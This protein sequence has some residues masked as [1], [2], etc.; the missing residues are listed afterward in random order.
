[1]MQRGTTRSFAVMGRRRITE[2]EPETILDHLVRLT[3]L[4]AKGPDG[5][6]H[7]TTLGQALLR[8]AQ[9]GDAQDADEGVLMLDA[10]DPI[11]YPA[12]IGRISEVG[13]ALLIDPYLK[14]DSISHLLD[15][16]QVDR[17]LTGATNN[18]SHVI[19]IGLLLEMRSDLDRT[20][21]FRSS[22]ALHDRWVIPDSGGAYL[23]GTS[24]NGVGGRA[25]TI[26]CPMPEVAADAIRRK[27][28]DL[29]STAT[30]RAVG[31][32]A[33]EDAATELDDS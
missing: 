6:L 26:F 3:W 30:E 9:A 17:L 32:P 23:L 24:L 21:D 29:W 7:L 8:D 18:P 2:R 11:A 13:P 28:E 4:S 12:L 19:A 27:C 25:A 22:D 1:M 10:G 5:R 20:V 16:T 33:D 15:H 31:P 14:P